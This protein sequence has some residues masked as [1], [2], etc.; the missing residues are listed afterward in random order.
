MFENSFDEKFL[1][2]IAESIREIRR[3][4]PAMTLNSLQTFLEVALDDGLLLSSLTL[5]SRSSQSSVSRNVILLAER[6]DNPLVQVSFKQLQRRSKVV[7]LTA[8]GKDLVQLIVARG[9]L[10]I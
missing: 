4:Y 5:R 10:T 2:C 3:T 1:R 6:G 9:A 8:D 7:E